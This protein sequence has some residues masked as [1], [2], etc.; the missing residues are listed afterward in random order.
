[1]NGFDLMEHL[2]AA[3]IV[4]GAMIVLIT[5]RLW[6][7]RP[8]GSREY[9]TG[10]AKVISRRVAQKDGGRSGTSRA[11]PNVTGFS[12]WQ[13][14]VTFEVG[15]QLLELEVQEGDYGRLKE[16]LTGEL[17]WQYEYLVS[18]DPDTDS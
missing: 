9:L 18:F 17:E 10:H 15:P 3:V 4:L 16:G 13:Y 5:Y 2:K 8:R 6:I 12:R 7:H 1:M 14:L 11:N